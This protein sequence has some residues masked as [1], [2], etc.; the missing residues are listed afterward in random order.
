MP[1]YRARCWWTVSGIA[2]DGSAEQGRS[3]ARSAVLELADDALSCIAHRVDRAD[4]LLLADHDLVEQ[5]FE[6]RRD[7][8]V[9]QRRIGLFEN[10][11][12]RQA[13]L[14]GHDVLSL[15]DKKILFL[16][17]SYDLGSRRRRAD[18]L[19][20]LQTLPQSF[21]IDKAPGGL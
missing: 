4:D 3:F 8:R 15:G 7:A 19:G 5:A 18:S 17:P 6:L 16:Q 12:Q 10:P 9:D 21:I 11:E 20:L 2:V 14:G 13:G 1:F